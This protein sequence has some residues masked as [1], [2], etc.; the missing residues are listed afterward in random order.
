[1]PKKLEE[2]KIRHAPGI[3]N[4]I[5]WLGKN[6]KADAPYFDTEEVSKGIGLSLN[7]IRFLSRDDG[8]KP[9]LKKVK[10]I[11]G[12]KVYWST[13]EYIKKL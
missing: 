3:F 9:Y 7:W 4:I 13:P 10:M 6:V 5:E 8:L 2:I 12:F 1:M 11:H